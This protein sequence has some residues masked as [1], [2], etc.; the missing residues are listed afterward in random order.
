VWDIGYI[1]VVEQLRSIGFTQQSSIH[2]LLHW[3]F[4]LV[5]VLFLAKQSIGAW[6]SSKY[7][8][9][10]THSVRS[11]K[12]GRNAKLAPDARIMVGAQDQPNKLIGLQLNFSPDKPMMQVE[13]SFQGLDHL[14]S[15]NSYF[16]K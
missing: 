10:C 12:L 15:S 6:V 8:M 14:D 16:Y 7:R 11:I 5:D 1:Y 9:H 3:V 2:I 13:H 4:G